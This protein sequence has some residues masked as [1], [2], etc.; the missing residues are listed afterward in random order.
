MQATESCQTA[1]NQSTWHPRGA[2]AKE[3]Q[4][5]QPGRMAISSGAKKTNRLQKCFGCG[6]NQATKA[7]IL[8]GKIHEKRAKQNYSGICRDSI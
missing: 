6:E 3:D 4:H 8:Q 7:A 2:E 5:R 1:I